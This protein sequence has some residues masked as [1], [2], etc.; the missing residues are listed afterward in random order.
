MK[1]LNDLLYGKRKQNK[2]KKGMLL[3]PQKEV[4]SVKKGLVKDGKLL[5]VLIFVFDRNQ[6]QSFEE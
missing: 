2:F 5:I 6:G 4:N 1:K 3:P